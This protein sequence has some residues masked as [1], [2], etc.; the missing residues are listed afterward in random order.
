MPLMPYMSPAAI[1]STSVRPRGWPVARKRSPSACSVRSGV[2]RPE[3]ELAAT[4]AP[5]GIAAT[6]SS[7]LTTLLVVIRTTS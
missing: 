5:S 7:K 2:L 4:T 1:G 6:A 3:D